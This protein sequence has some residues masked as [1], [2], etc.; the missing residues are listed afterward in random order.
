MY[1]A[2]TSVFWLRLYVLPAKTH[3]PQEKSLSPLQ[4]C[5]RVLDHPT[6][7]IEAAKRSLC[8]RLEQGNLILLI[9]LLGGWHFWSGFSLLFSVF[10]I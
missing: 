7:E 10:T 1:L 2:D 9:S 5:R 8:F 6:P 3:A 4:W